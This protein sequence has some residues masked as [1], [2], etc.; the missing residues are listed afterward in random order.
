MQYGQIAE[1]VKAE[2]LLALQVLLNEQQMAFNQACVGRD[3]TVLFDRDGREP[4]QAIGRSP[5]MQSVHVNDCDTMI[6]VLADVRI[7]RALA[8]SLAGRLM[9][10]AEAPAHAA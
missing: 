4:G 1:S 9:D 10:G 5:Y 3:L 8:N 7:E 2:R 6:G